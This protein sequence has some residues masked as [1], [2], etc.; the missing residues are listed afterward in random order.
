[1]MT[2]GAHISPRSYIPPPSVSSAIRT[3]SYG[4]AHSIK[5]NNLGAHDESGGANVQVS[6]KT[7]KKKKSDTIITAE[8]TR[9]KVA[10]I[11]VRIAMN[12]TCTHEYQRQKSMCTIMYRPSRVYYSWPKHSNVYDG[13]ANI[14]PGKK[15]RRPDNGRK[16][17]QLCGARKVALVTT[18]CRTS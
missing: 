8:Q 3:T 15:V 1:M 7:K 17:Y 12:D 13:N 4:Y 18:C 14:L 9:D 11:Y 2:R 6:D 16:K 5:L 10:T